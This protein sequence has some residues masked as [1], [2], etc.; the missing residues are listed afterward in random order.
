M[1]QIVVVVFDV[2]LAQDGEVACGTG[3]LHAGQK[4][5]SPGEDE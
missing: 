2:C 5:A 4:L 1:K 3:L